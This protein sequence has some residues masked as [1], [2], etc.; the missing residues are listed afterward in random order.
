LVRAK[1]EPRRP[2]PCRTNSARTYVEPNWSWSMSSRCRVEFILADIEPSQ[3]RSKL[4]RVV[5][6][7]CQDQSVW[8]DVELTRF[9]PMSSRCRVESILVDVELSRSGSKLS[10]SCSE[11]MWS[12]VGLDRC[13]TESARTDSTRHGPEPTRLHM[14]SG[15]LGLT[16][17]H[18]TWL[19]NG[20]VDSTL[21]QAGPSRF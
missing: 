18:P 5:P 16:S 6:S 4:S 10:L 1:V 13:Q 9:G 20:P 7:P 17:T 3:S 2:D 14:D 12:R 8:V 15:P 21:H 19:N 11:S